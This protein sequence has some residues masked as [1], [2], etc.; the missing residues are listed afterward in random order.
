[1]PLTETPDGVISTVRAVPRAGRDPIDGVLNGAMRVRLAAPPVEG[2]G[3]QAL[4]AL[5]AAALGAPPRDVSIVH[6]TRGRLKLVWARGLTAGDAHRR[7][8]PLL[9]YR[10]GAAAPGGNTGPDVDHDLRAI[11]LVSSLPVRQGSRVG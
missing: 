6:G 4:V 3:N 1:M 11:R 10:R 2:A 7:L 5:L 9:G 8:A